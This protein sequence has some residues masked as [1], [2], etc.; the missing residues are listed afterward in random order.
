MSIPHFA[1]ESL[2]MSYQC[3][4]TTD[5]STQNPVTLCLW[6]SLEY[7]NQF[8]PLTSQSFNTYNLSYLGLEKHLTVP[9]ETHGNAI[10]PTKSRKKK[11]GNH[12]ANSSVFLMS[13]P[14]ARAMTRLV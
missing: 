14:S 2:G 12:K 13:F 4:T 7:L 10:N 1:H 8:Q 6:E 3:Y 5:K 11:G 9:T